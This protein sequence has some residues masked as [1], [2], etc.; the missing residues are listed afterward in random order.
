MMPVH[1]HG[2]LHDC[3]RRY[4]HVRKGDEVGAFDFL[5]KPFRE[6]DL[7]DTIYRA[8][9]AYGQRLQ[10]AQTLAV[11]NERLSSLTAREREVLTA[12]SKGL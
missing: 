3:I 1:L 5:Q 9:R 2:G 8:D 7:I 12:W 4:Q 11:T 6:Q 10:I